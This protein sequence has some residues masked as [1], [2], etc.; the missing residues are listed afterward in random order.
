MRE[1]R[2]REWSIP[3][4][5]SLTKQPTR[6]APSLR[7]AAKS[8]ATAEGGAVPSIGRCDPVA[9]C[10]RPT[11]IQSRGLGTHRCPIPASRGPSGE[12]FGRHCVTLL[13]IVDQATTCVVRF[14]IIPILPAT[15]SARIYSEVLQS[16][17]VF[18]RA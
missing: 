7:V 13:G 1:R 6:K 18:Q 10:K 12:A 5:R 15:R 16:M 8:G 14:V 4:A 9:G 17:S 2:R 3:F 11:D